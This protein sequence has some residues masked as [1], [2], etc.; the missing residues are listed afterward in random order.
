MEN[1]NLQY[2][3]TAL[4]KWPQKRELEIYSVN[5]RNKQHKHIGQLFVFRDVTHEREVDR[6]KSEFVSLVSHELRTPL[7]SINGYADMLLEG[8]AGDINDEQTD[9][10]RVIKRNS[11]RL[12]LLINELLD[13]S[14][15][16]AG[17]LKLSISRINIAELVYEVVKSIRP[18]IESKEQELDV[19]MPQDVPV[20]MADGN[21]ITQI[22]T[23][24]ISNAHKYT[25]REGKISVVVRPE[26]NRFRIDVKDTGIGLSK[27]EQERL[28]TKFFRADNPSTQKVAGAG[29]GLWITNSLVEMHGGEMTVSSTPGKGSIF[30][31]TLPLE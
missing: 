23:N 21:R 30:S 2:K 25:P 12:S 29:L 19:E 10:L 3:E 16:E 13:V 28:F 11:E 17:A 7:T 6:M 26:S 18:Q 27:D 8:D 5:V 9:F 22:L 4:Q 31:F 20:V 1:G 24:L 14:R 15:I